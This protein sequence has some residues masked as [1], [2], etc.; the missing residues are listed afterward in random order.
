MGAPRLRI[1]KLRFVFP[2]PCIPVCCQYMR[3]KIPALAALVLSFAASG[4]VQA[5]PASPARAYGVSATFNVGGE[6]G[7]DY[8]TVD[9]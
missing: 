9:P 6:G 5:Q 7:W 8:L 1:G 4:L 2:S 3:M